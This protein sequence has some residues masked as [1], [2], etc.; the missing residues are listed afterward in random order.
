MVRLREVVKAGKKLD[1]QIFSRKASFTP[2]KDVSQ[3]PI[4]RERPEPQNSRLPAGGTPSLSVTVVYSIKAMDEY[5]YGS[6]VKTDIGISR[7]VL[8]GLGSAVRSFVPTETVP[9][10]ILRQTTKTPCS[11]G[12]R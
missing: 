6:S 2:N 10:P 3:R 7:N 4:G 12:G 1:D 5:S 11:S 8:R 9:V